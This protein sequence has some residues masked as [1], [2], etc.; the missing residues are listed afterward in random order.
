[1]KNY[2][3]NYESY[4]DRESILDYLDALKQGF[5]D[6]KIEL[7]TNDHEIILKPSDLIKLNISS[8]KNTLSLSFSFKEE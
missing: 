5:I 8:S 4:Q 1:M 6:G 7:R 3:F 2:D